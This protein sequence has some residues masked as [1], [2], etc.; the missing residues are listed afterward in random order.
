M[1]V[2]LGSVMPAVATLGA[3]VFKL[4]ALLFFAFLFLA[5]ALPVKTLREWFVRV[6]CLN[7]TPSVNGGT[8][9]KQGK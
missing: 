2:V 7:K 6:A 4:I 8:S 5:L 1:G 9:D 3:A